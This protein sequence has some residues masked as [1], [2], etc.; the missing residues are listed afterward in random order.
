MKAIKLGVERLCVEGEGEME[1]YPLF[2]EQN[3]GMLPM[4]E[5]ETNKLMSGSKWW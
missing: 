4:V 2:S 3:G 5:D 1:R